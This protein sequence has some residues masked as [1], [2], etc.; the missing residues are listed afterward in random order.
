M[1]PLLCF[2]FSMFA[3]TLI[4]QN[5][6]EIRY[7]STM[8]LRGAEGIYV[9]EF[10][11]K[12]QATKQIQIIA[13]GQNP[14]FMAIHRNKQFLYAI[15]SEGIER[16]DGSGGVIAYRIHPSTGELTR[17]NEQSANGQGPCHI[18]IEPRGQFAYVSHYGSGNLAVLPIAPDG[19]LG[20]VTQVIQHEGSSTHERQK[21]PHVHSMILGHSGQII[22]A[23][24][25]GTDQII[26][27]RIDPKKGTLSTD[28]A[29]ATKTQAGAGPRHF[30]LAAHGRVAYS[31]EELSSTVAVYQVHPK[32]HA[33]AFVQRLPMLPE[34]FS[35]TNLAADIHL[36]PDGRFL[37]AT[38]RGHD[39]IA[40]FA[41]QP[42][43]GTLTFVARESTRGG[44]PRN[45]LIDPDGQHVWIA[46]RD[47]DNVVLFE[48]NTTTGLLNYTGREVK[49]PA[50]VCVLPLQLK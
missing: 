15:C 26:G 46:N 35:G 7:V 4:A 47:G 31:V 45:F 30:V 18:A 6:K 3:W 25:L 21:S 24:D 12:T 49:L 42:K 13:A 29:L 8:S 16:K 36:S 40:I 27:Y 32:T 1:K 50:P 38:N 44:H 2:L 34:G 43:T 37:Y 39:S 41:V 28:A 11:R 9:Y 48:R 23:S 17:L 20:K 33:L 22:Y 5:S 14:T 19:T 10:D